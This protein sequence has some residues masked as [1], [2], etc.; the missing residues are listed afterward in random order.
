MAKDFNIVRYASFSETVVFNFDQ[1]NLL[2]AGKTSLLNKITKLI[3]TA[4][5]SNSFYEEF[6]NPFYNLLS[7]TD[8]AQLEEFNVV[9]PLLIGSITSQIKNEQISDTGLQSDEKLL[10]LEL[11]GVTFDELSQTYTILINV[12]TADSQETTLRI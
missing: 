3:L 2:L 4:K 10:N 9:I 6:G 7:S 12:I 1:D 5:G 8:P 11:I